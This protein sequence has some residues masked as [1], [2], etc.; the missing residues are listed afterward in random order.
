MAVSAE[1]A[2]SADWLQLRGDRHM[3]GHS[4]GRGQ[5]RE[6]PA[7]AWNFD[8]A[9]WEGYMSI[10]PSTGLSSFELPFPY[11]KDP[12]YLGARG[13]DW[14]I[15][16]QRFDL[17]GDGIF[18]D[19]PINHR[20]KV[21]RILPDLVGLQRFEM[22][23]SFD[24]G[25]AGEQRGSLTAYDGSESRV[26]WKTETFSDTWAPNV[27]IVDADAAKIKNKLYLIILLIF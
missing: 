1:N 15:G 16:P 23:D 25:G 6:S 24:D 2:Q 5:M 19:M 7:E 11:Q 22:G 14:G 12:G 18:T 10:Q 4:S 9:V 21:A 13:R 27:L 26:V 3:I 8:I 17:H 20:F